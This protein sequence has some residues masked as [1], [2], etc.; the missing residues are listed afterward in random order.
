MELE[1]KMCK[2]WAL[3]SFCTVF[4]FLCYLCT[5][6]AAASPPLGVIG[7]ALAGH[8]VATLVHLIKISLHFI[9]I[10]EY[11]FLGVLNDK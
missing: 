11:I 4:Y 2:C 1:A 5:A 6:L 10:L 3:F 8:G 9:P 7:G